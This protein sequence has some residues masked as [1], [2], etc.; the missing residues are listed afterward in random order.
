MP[1]SLPLVLPVT[2]PLLGP[3]PEW[4]GHWIRSVCELVNMNEHLSAKMQAEKPGETGVLSFLFHPRKSSCSV[5]KNENT[6]RVLVGPHRSSPLPP[7]PGHPET[8]IVS[9]PLSF[10]G[11][12]QHLG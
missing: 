2:L 7:S 5:R 3:G 4:T 1:H 8:P 12:F 10:P 9:S 11:K 6:Q